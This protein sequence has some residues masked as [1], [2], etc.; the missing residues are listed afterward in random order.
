MPDIL[1]TWVYSQDECIH[2]ERAC[3]GIF[4]FFF[5]KSAVYPPTVPNTRTRRSGGFVVLSNIIKCLHNKEGE[6]EG[7]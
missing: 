5:F 1:E 6:Q 3:G 7:K 4:F 2:R